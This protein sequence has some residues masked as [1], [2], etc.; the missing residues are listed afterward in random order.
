VPSALEVVQE[1]FACFDRGDLA[2]AGQLV[3]D[4]AV[5]T[6]FVSGEDPVELRG[7]ENFVS[8]YSRRRELLGDSFS[9]R[10]DELLPGNRHAVALI[11]LSRG[12]DARRTNG[13]QVAVYTVDR[14]VI[15]ALHG[16]EEP[17]TRSGSW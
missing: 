14:G 9:Y 5:I 3:A 17:Q 15:T 6:L 16:Y 1:F 13:R 10:V 8:W 4:D 11:A 12:A 7:F 2:R